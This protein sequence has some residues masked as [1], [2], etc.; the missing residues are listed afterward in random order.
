MG[1][2]PDQYVQREHSTSVHARNDFRGRVLELEIEGCTKHS[3]AGAK[4]GRQW[5][6][7]LTRGPERISVT[8][9][10]VSDAEDAP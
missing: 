7:R 9:E 5:A 3:E 1:E 10:R 4:Y 8:I 6:C 2:R